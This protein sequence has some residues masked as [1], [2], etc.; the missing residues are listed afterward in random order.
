MSNALL[1]LLLAVTPSAY[2]AEAIPVRGFERIGQTFAY[3]GLNCWGTAL[4]AAGLRDL[5]QYAEDKEFTA[6]LAQ[7][8]LCRPLAV[9]EAVPY[10]AVGALRHATSGGFEELHGFVV[11]FGDRILTTKDFTFETGMQ[12]R[13]LARDFALFAEAKN[14]FAACGPELKNGAY[15][16]GAR[17]CTD[18]VDFYACRPGQT[19]GALVVDPAA[20]EVRAGVEGL[21]TELEILLRAGRPFEEAR[22]LSFINE[23][24]ALMVKA[25]ALPEGQDR[26]I[27]TALY[28]SMAMQFTSIY[29]QQ[30]TPSQLAD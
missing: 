14:D 13:S 29:G 24:S 20:R 9:G 23:M 21:M 30:R 27:V 8:S 15:V 11:L 3:D 2:A 25:Y 22:G 10:G 4:Y 7:D 5:Y 12:Y 1:A 16:Q 26:T 19:I 28:A 18:W 17:R 6:T